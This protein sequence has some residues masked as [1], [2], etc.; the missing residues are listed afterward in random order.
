MTHPHLHD[1]PAAPGRL[2]LPRSVQAASA[3]AVLVGG[4]ALGWAFASGEPELAWSSYLI[5]AFFALGLGAFG[6]AWLAMLCLAGADWS[7]TMRRIP[8]AMTAWLLPGGVLVMTIALGAQALQV[9]TQRLSG[10][11]RQGAIAQRRDDV[12]P[13]RFLKP[14]RS[15]VRPLYQIFINQSSDGAFIHHA[16]LK[17]LELLTQFTGNANRSIAECIADGFDNSLDWH[18]SSNQSNIRE[19]W[20]GA[21]VNTPA[22]EQQHRN[23]TC[24]S[25]ECQDRSLGEIRTLRKPAK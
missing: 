15:F 3:A 6:V 12:K 4:G 13:H 11:N 16:A 1:F 24:D 10:G 19:L 9:C 8:E 21:K 2:S 5:G 18:E 23:R 22:R 20:K 25:E 7:V 17:F 14:V